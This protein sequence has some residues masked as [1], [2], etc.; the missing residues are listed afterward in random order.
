MNFFIDIGI[1]FF[2]ILIHGKKQILW[3]CVFSIVELLKKIINLE[4]ILVLKNL[5]VYYMY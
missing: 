4:F 5:Q 3:S 1:R 2:N